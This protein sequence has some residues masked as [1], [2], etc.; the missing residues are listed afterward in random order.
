MNTRLV[1]ELVRLRYKLLWARTRSRNGKIALFFVGY[2][3]F[4]AVA[5]LLVVG[6]F[7]AGV[8]AV[9]FGKAGLVAAI[10]LASLFV[11]T[12]FCT[13]VMGFG[14]NAV[15]SD[16]ELRR[17]PL[18]AFDRRAARH[19]TGILDPFWFLLLA[20]ELGLVAGLYLL[21]AANFWLG[22]AAALLLFF[23]CYLLA[24]IVA[25]VVD[26]LVAHKTGSAVLLV[27]VLSL[28]FL[29]GTLTPL[30]RHNRPLL[31][32]VWADVQWLPPF[33]SAQAIT[34]TGWAQI[35]GF[36]YLAA[37]V[38]LLLLL[39]VTLER[40]PVERFETRPA[41][42]LRWGVAYERLGAW[43]G[44]R[45]AP[46]VGHWLRF[47]L[48]NNRFR[49]MYLLSLP[50]GAF[51]IYN[52]TRRGS[53]REFV[54]AGLGVF[55][56]MAFMGTSRIAVNQFGYVGGGFRRFF[57]LPADPAACLRT[58]SYA[59]LLLA[60]PLVLIGAA[61]WAVLAPGPFDPRVE[62]MLLA[63]GVGG[64]L[65]FHGAAQ[66]TSVYA[67][68]RGNYSSSMGNDMSLGGNLLVIGSALGSLFLPEAIGHWHPALFAPTNWFVMIVPFAL[69]LGFYRF[70]LE[71]AGHR[72]AARR[73]R[74]LALVEGRG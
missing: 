28:S 65:F 31:H 61:A 50:L 3:L 56:V 57:L 40:R 70:S 58:G 23:T 16:A 44:A 34:A 25:L 73:E 48:R 10:V 62:A 15:F 54:L 29:P 7:G 33:A 4:I 19:L 30:L 59:A 74:L 17:Y 22:L 60:S 35:Q 51:L 37:W 2:L 68:R 11:E 36:L 13:V 9:R 1:G 67:P 24:R 69:A 26:R 49:A 63:S 32:R 46:L 71:Q 21:G 45:N 64:L 38:A 27:V 43:F 66:W 8:A 39:L 53:V 41:G 55:P 12:L 20:L 6:G 47:Y 42:A 72:L 14:L 5:I 18:T 52:F